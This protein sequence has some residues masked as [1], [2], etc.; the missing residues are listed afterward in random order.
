MTEPATLPTPTPQATLETQPFW[1]AAAAGRLELPRC[2]TCNETIWY[3]RL[4]CPHC[5]GRDISWFEASG[6]G[7]IYSF[8]VVERGQGRWKEHSP[9]VLAYVELDEG[10]RLMTNIV[11]CD[12]EAVAVD[13]PVRVVWHDTGEGNALPRFT[14]V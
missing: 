3:P 2:S 14:L 8:T 10:P 9:Y 1:D 13:A 5:G 4:Y 7:Q 6:S 11:D 12:P